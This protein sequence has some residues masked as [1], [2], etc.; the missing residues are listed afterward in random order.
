MKKIYFYVAVLAAIF[1]GCDNGE[2]DNVANDGQVAI[3]VSAGIEGAK[4][5]MIDTKWETRDKIGIFGKSGKLEYSNR[6]SF[7]IY[8][9]IDAFQVL[10]EFLLIFGAHI[11]DGVTNLMYDTKLYSSIGINTLDCFRK[12]FQTVYTGYKDIFN[13][14]VLEV[15]QHTEPE[16]CPLIP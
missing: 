15:C 8:S 12:T 10:Q 5:R 7:F 2:M 9:L 13:S 16:V 14:T 4:T 6:C 3:E 11:L 1:A